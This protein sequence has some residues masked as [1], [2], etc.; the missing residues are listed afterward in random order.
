MAEPAPRANDGRFTTENA[1]FYGRRGAAARE[2]SPTKDTAKPISHEKRA[3]CSSLGANDGFAA[4]G[5]AHSASHSLGSSRPGLAQVRPCRR[6]PR[7]RV[8]PD[9]QA[10]C[11]ISVLTWTSHQLSRSKQPSVLLRFSWRRLSHSPSQ[12]IR[13]CR[14]PRAPMSENV[15]RV[16]LASP[17]KLS[18]KR[19]QSGS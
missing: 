13:E 5:A 8:P 1:A 12:E 17:A 2:P 18:R 3:T 10:P 9:E 19:Q 6:N 14:A 16:R 4:T 7:L 15:A 11:I